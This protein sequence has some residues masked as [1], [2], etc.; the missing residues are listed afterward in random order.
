[1]FEIGETIVCDEVRVFPARTRYQSE[2]PSGAG[3]SKMV[4]PSVVQVSVSSGQRRKRAEVAGFS[5]FDKR[6]V[7]EHRVIARCEEMNCWVKFVALVLIAVVLV[8]VIAPD[9]DLPPTARFS[10]VR[11][12]VHPAAFNASLPASIILL[13]PNCFGSTTR[14]RLPGFNDFSINLIDLNCTRLC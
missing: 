3:A 9:V 8:I 13:R 5:V 1:M 10:S 4:L 2:I 11:H 7:A 6:D 14:F 12:R